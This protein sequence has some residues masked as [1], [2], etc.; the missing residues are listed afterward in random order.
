MPTQFDTTYHYKYSEPN[1]DS[2]DDKL[3]AQLIREADS[4]LEV[5]PPRSPTREEELEYQDW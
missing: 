3:K 5:K 1:Y 4:V 2:L